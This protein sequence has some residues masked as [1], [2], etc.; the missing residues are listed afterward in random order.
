M[1]AIGDF[2]SFFAAGLTTSLAPNTSTT[3]AWPNSELM[4]SISNTWS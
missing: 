1:P 3:S 4:S 2:G